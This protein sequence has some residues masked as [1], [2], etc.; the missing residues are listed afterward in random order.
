MAGSLVFS[1]SAASLESVFFSLSAP[2]ES[3]P[4]DSSSFSLFR[5]VG[6]FSS[7]LLL[8]VL[9][10]DGGGV[11][12]CLASFAADAEILKLFIIYF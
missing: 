12:C 3:F 10:F 11:G 4:A 8:A 2:E 5:G 7:F 6:F 1:P 9:S